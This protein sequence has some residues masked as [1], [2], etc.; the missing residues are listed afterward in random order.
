AR[1]VGAAPFRALVNDATIPALSRRFLAWAHLLEETG[2]LHDAAEAMLQ[3][4]WTADD[5]HRPDLARAWRREAVALWRSG[6]RL[7]PEQSLKVI[8]AL[9]R[10]ED[11][12][13]A[14]EAVA[15]LSAQ[16]LPEALRQVLALE[17]RLIEARD[18]R[19]HSLASALLPPARR[20]HASHQRLIGRGSLFG[21]L[22]RL[23]GR[24]G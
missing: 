17:A 8:D 13:A 12:E 19:R 20:P 9:R 2:K 22:K 18:A 15:S 24:R 21:W 4:A 7:D 1:V 10:A 5:L 11:W 6:P 16:D 14:E 23:L 3:A